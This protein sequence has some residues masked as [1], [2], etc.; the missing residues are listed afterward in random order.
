MPTS[1]SLPLGSNRFKRS[2]FNAMLNTYLVSGRL[3]LQLLVQFLFG[4]NRR[5]RINLPV[6]V[7]KMNGKRRRLLVCYK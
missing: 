5:G 3:Y 1:N 2:C 7:D 6:S 4:L